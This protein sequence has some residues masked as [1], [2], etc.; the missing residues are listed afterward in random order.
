[1]S[2]WVQPVVELVGALIVPFVV[3]F[4]AR[5]SAERRAK[6]LK[7]GQAV[8]WVCRAQWGRGPLRRGKL[9]APGFGKPLT[10]RPRRGKPWDVPAD[11]RVV[12]MRDEPTGMGDNPHV[13][14]TSL[15][16]QAASR[17]PLRLRLLSTDAPLVQTALGGAAPL[18]GGAWDAPWHEPARI[19][20][21]RWWL[22][23]LAGA[24]MLGLGVGLTMF[25]DWRSHH[26]VV[27]VLANDGKQHC[28]VTW[29]DPWTNEPRKGRLRC[30]DDDWVDGPL[31]AGERAD[32]WVGDWPFRGEVFGSSSEGDTVFSAG[33]WTLVLGLP[34]TVFGLLAA[35]VAT[36]RRLARRRYRRA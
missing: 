31:R 12:G 17:E 24:L 23:A 30:L 20:V 16:Y 8:T 1:V 10:F 32:A 6:E 13:G 19:P 22:T 11:G 28:R 33:M 26:V 2:G 21:R 3:H 4:L 9:V 14:V 29:R 34:V 36:F 35:V 25:A 7:E 15:F 18:A 5:R 27:Q